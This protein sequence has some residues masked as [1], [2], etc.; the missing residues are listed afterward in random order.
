MIYLDL[1]T[2]SA[3]F[4]THCIIIRL[5]FLGRGT[6]RKD[7]RPFAG[8]LCIANVDALEMGGLLPYKHN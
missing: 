4:P 6:W 3:E 1:R 8:R 7:P 5:I 2:K